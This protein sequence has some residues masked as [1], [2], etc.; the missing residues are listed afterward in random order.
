MKNN[1]ILVVLVV[2]LSVTL[3]GAITFAQPPGYELEKERGSWCDQMWF[4]EADDSSRISWLLNHAADV[5]G[6]SSPRN[7]PTIKRMTDGIPNPGD[8]QRLVDAGFT[9]Q[10]CG[11]KG[12]FDMYFYAINCREAP[13]NDPNF[14]I[15][16]AY[17]IDKDVIVPSLFGPLAMPLYNFLPPAQEFWYNPF[18]EATFPRFNLQAAIDT[19]MAGGYTPVLIDS[20]RAPVPGNIDHWHMPGGTADVRD[21]E[22]A[23][24][25]ESFLGMP[26][27]E[28]IELDLQSVG[29]P[30]RH[31][32]LPFNFILNSQ[33]LGGAPWDLTIGLG[34]S[35]TQNPFLYEMFDGASIPFWNIWGLNDPAVNMWTTALRESLDPAIA[36]ANAFAAQ[37]ALRSAMPVVPIMVSNEWTACPGPYDGEPGFLGW[38][39][40]KAHGGYNLWS[41]L[42]SRREEVDG[43]IVQDS[44]W[45]TAHWPTELNP[46]LSCTPYDWLVLS[47]VYSTLLYKNPYT[48]ELMPW[49]V[50]DM[51]TVQPW[52]TGTYMSWTLRDDMTWHDGTPVTA[53]DVEFC[54]DLL[55]RQNNQRYRAIQTLIHDVNVVDT[56]TFEVYL[57]GSYPW[58]MKDISDVALLTPYHVWK[59]YIAG[60]DQIL[61]TPDDRDHRYWTG[62]DVIDAWGYSAPE[63]NTPKGTIQLTH[64]QG[65]GPFIYPYGGWTPGVSMKLIRWYDASTEPGT[66]WHYTRI[67]RGDNNLDG[68]VDMIDLWAPLYAYGT[69]PCMPRWHFD[70]A[71]LKA[72]QANPAALIDGR[73]VQKVYDDWGLYWWPY[74]TLPP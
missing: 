44:R 59:P 48:H 22:Q 49:C 60:P 11:P 13:L 63:I 56:Y 1:H 14:R 41:T 51:P 62:Y 2:C 37:V 12:G 35:L 19:L 58:A 55:V 29:I 8:I 28:W 42:Y 53:Y 39:N 67:L 33:W 23:V 74:S 43:S 65:N 10:A 31:T 25:V 57:T 64:L 46:L 61:W 21:L 24:P 38:V 9:V 52:D 73:D 16:L 71:G 27:S 4:Y 54:L 69:Q 40:M 5:V 36:Q 68:L 47:L 72:D 32:P 45:L 3:L 66:G 15:A 20:K 70:N 17:C 26:M 30:V 50:T 34:F 7:Y 6:E 18:G